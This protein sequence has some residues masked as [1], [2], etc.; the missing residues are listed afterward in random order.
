MAKAF[1]IASWNV[2]HF[3]ATP[4]GKTKPTKPIDPI[5]DFLASQNADVVAVYEVVGSIIYDTISAK[6]PGYHFHITEGPQTQEILVGVKKKF[7]SFFSQKVT[8]KSGAAALRPGALLTLRIDG[9]NYPLLFLH[10]K[11]LSVPKG[12]GLRDDMIDR[13][14]KLRKALNK[15]EAK[16]TGFAEANFV[17]LGDLNT[18]GMNLTYNDK[19]I[20][21]VEE[22]ERLR[23]RLAISSVSMELLDKNA[24]A[25][26]WPG[27]PSTYEP[28]DLDHVL[29]ASHLE[30]K[31]FGGVSV[32][33]RGWVD[34]GTDAQRNAWAKKFSDHALLYCEVQKV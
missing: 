2:E 33:V 20:S 22:I 19:D 27:S 6:M 11:S 12:F 9:Q 16:T 23:N 5:F 8:F 3:G 4:K 1:S 30:F 7:S 14:I 10:L 21:G 32:D 28:S 15:H 13:L 25:T 17:A 26:Y 24:P 29:A 18:M 34:K 31:N